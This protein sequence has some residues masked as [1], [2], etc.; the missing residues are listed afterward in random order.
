[1]KPRVNILYAEKV[2]EIEGKEAYINPQ[3]ELG[4]NALPT[5]YNFV[6]VITLNGVDVSTEH[7]IQARFSAPDGT[8]L[9]ES[10]RVHTPTD[11]AVK[12]LRLTF[13]HQNIYMELEGNY[14]CQVFLDDE[15]LGDNFMFVGKNQPELI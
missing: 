9:F 2:L 1:M 11:I 13:N 5:H 12:T 8:I 15:L 10:D 14:L 7:V 6:T 3:W 4:V